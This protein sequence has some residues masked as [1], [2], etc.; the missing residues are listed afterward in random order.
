MQLIDNE[1]GRSPMANRDVDTAVLIDGANT[2]TAAKNLG[3]D[4]DYSALLRLLNSNFNIRRIAY[5]TALDD[6]ENDSTPLRPLV[7]WLCYNG[8]SVITKPAKILYSESGQR[9]IK[10]N[11]DI[12]IAVDALAASSFARHIILFTG[13]GD[14]I[15]LLVEL[16]RRG[17]RV[18]IISSIRTQP[19]M[20]ADELRKQADVFI[21]LN[22]LKEDIIKSRENTGPAFSKM[23]LEDEPIHHV[24]V[25]NTLLK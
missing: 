20:C 19:P 7:D 3:F 9:K 15:P 22:D 8:Y 6:D 1:N 4:I 11:M 10:G 5:Y 24:N 17:V 2:F 25:E 12:E 13:D 21:D 18:T 16:Q 14:F 23:P